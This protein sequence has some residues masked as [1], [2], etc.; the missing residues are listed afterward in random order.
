MIT[1]T[2][3]SSPE[4]RI[5]LGASVLSAARVVDTRSI[6]DRLERFERVHGEY[7]DAEQK[8]E[9]AKAEVEAAHA[10]VSVSGTRQEKAVETLARTL[11]TDG[12]A[13]ANPFEAFGVPA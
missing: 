12:E 8:V 3:R 4:K 9:A 1:R 13:R 10:L 6:Q 11:V 5:Q 2:R 7:V